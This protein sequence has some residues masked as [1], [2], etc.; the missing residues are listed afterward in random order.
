MTVSTGPAYRVPRRVAVISAGPAALRLI[1]EG[2]AGGAPL[3]GTVLAA[4]RRSA[5]LSFGADALVCIGRRLLGNGPLNVVCDAEAGF[6]TGLV[7]DEPV[8]ADT[9]GLQL[10]GGRSLLFA[11]ARQWN[12]PALPPPTAWRPRAD[13]L[14]VLAD[15]IS[16]FPRQDGLGPLIAPLC[17]GPESLTAPTTGDRHLLAAAVP[18]IVR[19]LAWLDE[20]AR[21]ETASPAPVSRLIGLGP[22]LT[23]S[24]DDFLIGLL[25]GLHGLGRKRLAGALAASVRIASVE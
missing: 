1:E 20:S 5:Y 7:Q 9:D 19:L 13:I 16:R 15:R 3:H 18:A 11:R 2:Q 14:S 22:G 4:F 8:S 21:D 25:V 6:L 17:T 23:P 12:P 10:P 24:G